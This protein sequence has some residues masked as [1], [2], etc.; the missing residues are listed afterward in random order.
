MSIVLPVTPPY[1]SN[2]QLDYKVIQDLQILLWT[3]LQWLDRSYHLAK[4]G[5]DSENKS[6]Y[7]Q[8]HANNGTDEHFDIRPDKRISSYSFFEIDKPFTIDYN[9]KECNYYLSIVFWNNLELIDNT[10]QYDFTSEL[11]KDVVEVLKKRAG[12]N[13]VIETRPEQIFNKYNALKQENTQLLIRRFSAFKVTFNIKTLLANTCLPV[14]YDLCTITLAKLLALPEAT[15]DCIKLGFCSIGNEV[16][17]S[18][19]SVLY[20]NTSSDLEI[21]VVDSI[22][23]AV[24]S[25]DPNVKVS[26]ANSSIKDSAGLELHSVRAEQPEIIT[27][28]TVNVK[29]SL[30]TILYAKTVKAENTADQIVND[31]TILVKNSAN[32][33]IA[34]GTF[35]AEESGNISAPDKVFID[36]DL[37]VSPLVQGVDYTCTPQIQTVFLKGVWGVGIDTLPTLTIDTDNAGTYTSESTDGASGTLTY[38]INGGGYATFV[39]PTVLAVSD[40]IIAKRTVTTAVGYFKFNGTY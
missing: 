21:P 22:G 29:D 27:D 19:N 24:G 33:T 6:T 36:S 34:S 8:I 40:T 26:I 14:T 13:F 4:V 3:E 7:P 9:S 31:T 5:V 39:N 16:D 1:Y 15:Q 17:V 11:I 35:K 28:S 10:K 37:S 23:V 32:V 12:E 38:S 30:G 18:V 2:P 20:L 25:V